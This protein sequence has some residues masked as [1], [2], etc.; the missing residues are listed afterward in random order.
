MQTPLAPHAM[1][2]GPVDPRRVLCTMCE[3]TEFVHGDAETRLCLYS[4]CDC[5]GFTSGA[6][7]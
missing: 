2:L 6:G 1:L 5:H 3:H 4:E 7:A